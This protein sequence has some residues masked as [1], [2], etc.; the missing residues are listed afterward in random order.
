MNEIRIY[1][2]LYILFGYVCQYRIWLL[3][4]VII[5]YSKQLIIYEWIFENYSKFNSKLDS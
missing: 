5:L 4:S 2:S 3:Y 1:V